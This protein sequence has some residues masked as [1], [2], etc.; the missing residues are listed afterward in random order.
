MQ[1]H[2]KEVKLKN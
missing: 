2:F 1:Q